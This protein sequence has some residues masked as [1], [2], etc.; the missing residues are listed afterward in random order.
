[1][2]VNLNSTTSFSCIISFKSNIYSF[3]KIQINNKKLGKLYNSL[4][5]VC[6]NNILH[7][8]CEDFMLSMFCVQRRK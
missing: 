5:F 3:L 4:N 8:F 7:T 6:I 2:I 1:M